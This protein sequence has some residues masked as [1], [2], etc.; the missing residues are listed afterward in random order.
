[1]SDNQLINQLAGLC[2]ISSEYLDS[3][4]LPVTIAPENKIPPLE[5]MGFNVSSKESIKK[6]IKQKSDEKWNQSIPAVVVLHQNKPFAIEIRLPEKK[7]PEQFEI[8]VTLEYGEIRM[9]KRDL[10]ELTVVES[11]KV[12]KNNK[13]CLS[14]PLPADLPLGYH[15]LNIEGIA[16]ACSLIVAPETCYEPEALMS[17]G[18][19]WGSGIQ[20]YSVRSE[21]NWGMGDY[22]D[23]NDMVSQLADNGADFVGLN[24][25]HA[26]YADNPLH[27][28]PYSPSSRTY[29]NVLYINPE[30]VP[31]FSECELTRQLFAKDDFQ[32]HL[33]EARQQDYVDYETV[34][35]LKFEVLETLYDYFCKVHLKQNTERANAFHAFCQ[36]NGESLR[37]FATFDALFEHFRK[38]DIMS[39]GWPCWPEAYQ[40]PDTKEVKAFVK[41][42]E[43]RIRYFEFLQWLAS[44]QFA[45]AQKTA[46]EKGMMV[47]VYRDLAVGVDRGGA[48]TWSNPSLYCLDAS[49]GAPPDALGPQGQNWGLPPFN[50]L[51]LQ[52]QRYEPFIR[53]IRNNM[54]DCG[55]LR[56]DHAMGLFRLWW[57]PN[58]KSA[59]YGAY[60]HYPLQDLLG[61]I[62]LE[63]RRLNCLVFGED[64][65]TVPKEIEAALPPARLY[66]SLNGI[67]LQ[68]GDRY[69]MPSSFKPRAMAN[70]TCHDTPP[71]RGWWEEKDL[72]LANT[73]GIFDDE[74]T[75]QERLDR[76]YTRKAVINTL[77][78]IGELPSGINP[79]DEKSPGFS[80]ELMERFTYY[81]ALAESQITNVQLEDC[82]MI[83]TSVN[84]PGTSEEYPNWRRRLTVNLGE[85]FSDQENRRFFHNISQCRQ[86]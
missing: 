31:E 33:A 40:T 65:G 30:L 56:I 4:G 2:G 17:G 49:T 35:T 15:H 22:R 76:E 58:G 63:S 77:A 53:M 39:W 12:G 14:L 70:L 44:E 21:N 51:V 60:V 26:L 84:V 85:F 29:S 78:M 20:L 32:M 36:D 52:E 10:N 54:R 37:Q 19:I 5:A 28:S 72:D 75:H 64:L 3:E 42:N 13:V 62:K 24:P 73:L 68:E 57:C 86:A 9:F 81:L 6:A 11:A 47:G 41:K 50:P 46:T 43:K 45:A 66:S 61:I 67:H 16:S 71:L 74:R 7:L 55:A 79:Y 1:M 23:L 27:C 59:A 48:D 69:P 34:A 83:D 8:T 38:Q 18:K 80:R 25:V 82:M